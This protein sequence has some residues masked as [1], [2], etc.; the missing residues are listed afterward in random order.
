MRHYKVCQG[1]NDVYNSSHEYRLDITILC[2]Q[3]NS[4]NKDFQTAPFLYQCLFKTLNLQVFHMYRRYGE[5][6]TDPRKFNINLIGDNESWEWRFFAPENNNSRYRHGTKLRIVGRRYR[7]CKWGFNN[8]GLLRRLFRDELLIL[9]PCQ[10]EQIKSNSGKMP[11]PA[12]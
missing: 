6:P 3:V 1:K 7:S 8:S 4:P 5:F 12:A 9:I 10:E 2:I 11:T